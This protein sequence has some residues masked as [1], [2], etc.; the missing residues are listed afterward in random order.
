[1]LNEFLQ[2][3]IMQKSRA[4]Q[5]ITNIIA[6]ADEELGTVCMFLVIFPPDFV[7]K[8]NNFFRLVGLSVVIHKR[9]EKND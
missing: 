8:I 2:S 5:N 7:V 6:V 9:R 3:E 4:V 1:M